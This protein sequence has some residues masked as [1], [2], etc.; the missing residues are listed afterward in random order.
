MRQARPDQPRR[1][2]ASVFSLSITSSPILGCTRIEYE[3]SLTS[4]ASTVHVA[5]RITYKCNTDTPL[6]INRCRRDLL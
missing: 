3:V 4:D 5:E 1:F 6:G 2:H